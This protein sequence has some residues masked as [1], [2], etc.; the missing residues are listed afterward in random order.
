MKKNKFYEN[1]T[2]TYIIAEIGVNHNNSLKIAKKLIREAKLAGA[3]AVKFQTFSAKKLVLP[4]TRKVKYQKKN[5]NDKE[6]HFEMINC[7]ELSKK[8]HKILFQYCKKISIEFISTPYDVSSAKFLTKLGVKIFKTASADIIDYELHKYLS[9]TNKPVIIS[10]GMSTIKEIA[11]T[12]KIYKNNKKNISLLHC[13]SNYPCS[14]DS[15]NLKSLKLLKTKFN[16][17]IGYSDHSKDNLAS[18]L[19][20]ALSSKIIEKHFTLNK[21]LKGP[22][23]EV[24]LEPHEFKNMINGIK[25]IHSA[26]GDG[27]KTIHKNEIEVREWANHSVVSKIDIEKGEVITK[28]MVTVKRPSGG[29]KAK[30][31]ESV[32]SSRSKKRIKENTMIQW[33]DL[34]KKRNS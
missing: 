21:N 6:S 23:Y 31:F 26:L 32:L 15:I 14:Q 18:C 12:I 27:K 5:L 22:D 16:C 2:K 24:S 3:D 19:S 29:I 9:Q 17:T 10:T 20:I 8:Y 25:K 13:V 4:G 28:N 7:L 34:E 33:N 30:Y 1:L 11:A